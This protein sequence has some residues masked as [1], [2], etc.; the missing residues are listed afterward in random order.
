LDSLLATRLGEAQR[1]EALEPDEDL[2]TVM[3]RL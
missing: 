1:A 2:G 3:W